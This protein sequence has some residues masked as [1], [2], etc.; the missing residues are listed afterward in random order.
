MGKSR[1]GGGNNPRK[2]RFPGAAREE[3]QKSGGGKRESGQEKGNQGS[4]E[5][6]WDRKIGNQDAWK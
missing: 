2:W 4:I 6:K 1:D 5:I 3:K